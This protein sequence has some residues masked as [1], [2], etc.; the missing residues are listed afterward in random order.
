MPRVTVRPV[1]SAL[2]DRRRAN[3]VDGK[4]AVRLGFW[5]VRGL[6]QAGDRVTQTRGPHG[7]RDL[8]EMASRSG[9]ARRD[10]Q[11]LARAR[12]FDIFGL[13]RREVAACAGLVSRYPLFR[14]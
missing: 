3:G 1:C 10:L 2:H 14:H 5:L 6:G 11:C 7:F 13:T 8:A 9:L 4:L 12:A